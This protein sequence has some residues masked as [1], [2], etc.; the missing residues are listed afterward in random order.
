LD[1]S[2]KRTY[3]GMFL[4]DSAVTTANWDEVKSAIETV[5][6]RAGGEVI[7]IRKWDDRRLSY[8]IS[9]CKRGTYV[10]TYFKA[11]PE[12]IGGIERDV[13]LSEVIM[14]VLI[15]RADHL[16]SEAMEAPTPIMQVESEGDDE[17][18]SRSVSAPTAVAQAEAPPVEQVETAPVEEAADAPPGD[19]QAK[20][21]EN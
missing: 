4:I 17:S 18:E 9:G 7:S 2:V 5:F 10:L 20:D 12:A 1:T 21:L 14:R 16:S 6:Q 13:Q 8:E 19:D 15:L 11:L 3:E